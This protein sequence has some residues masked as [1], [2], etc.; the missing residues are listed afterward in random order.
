MNDDPKQFEFN[1]ASVAELRTQMETAQFLAKSRIGFV[2]LPVFSR[3]G[4]DF[5]MQHQA[6]RMN[7]LAS[8]AEAEQG[9]EAKEQDA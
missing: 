5:L 7:K 4:F 6:D 8:L 2:V 9:D 3:D 1:T